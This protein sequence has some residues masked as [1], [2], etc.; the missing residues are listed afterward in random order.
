[1]GW[2]QKAELRGKEWP[3]WI[4]FVAASAVEYPLSG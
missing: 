4:N 1:M 2:F 3:A